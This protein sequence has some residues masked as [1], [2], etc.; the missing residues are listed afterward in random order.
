MRSAPSWYSVLPLSAF[1][2]AS[3]GEKETPATP[4]EATPEEAV[5]APALP[6]VPA[7]PEIAKLSADERAEILGIVGRLAPETDAVMAIYDG[8]GLVEGLRSLKGWKFI[9]EMSEEELGV[10]PEE[11]VG[12]GGP[13][14]DAFLGD[15]FFLAFGD[16]T[17]EQLE[18][19]NKFNSRMTYYQVR[20]FTQAFAEGA[21][22]GDLESAM[23]SAD[24]NAW[25][26]EM[27]RDIGRYM[28]WIENAKA[29]GLLA[30]LRIEDDE[31]R[32]M[33]EQQLR[34]FLGYFGEEVETVEFEKGGAKFSGV[35]FPGSMFAEG[36]E[37][38]R[39]DMAEM[40]GEEATGE[41]IEAVGEK[42]LMVTIGT[43]DDYL[44]L[45]VGSDEEGCPL[46]ASVDESLA[47]SDEIGFIDEFKGQPVHGFL[48][49]AEAVTKAAVTTS[50]KD[51]AE[52]AR[53]GM[54]GVEGIGDTRELV[55][56]LD[57]VGEREA[58]LLDLF[59]PS[60][61]GGVI[62]IDDGL[63]FE[64][65][66][67]S[68]G[69][70]DYQT[71]HQMGALGEGENV[72]LF[73]NWVADETYMERSGEMAE[74]LI[75]TGYATAQHLATMDIE[76]EE[77]EEFQSYFGLFDSMLREDVVTLWEG[78][79]AMSD[80]LGKESAVVVDLN[81]PFPPIPGVPVQVVE[82]GRFVRASYVSPVVDR[83]KLKESWAS[84]YGS[85]RTMLKKLQEAELAELN[86]LS[87]T[88]SEKD[89]LVTW[90]FDALAFS[91]DVKPSVS[92]NDDWFVA[93]TSRN[94]AIDLIGSAGKPAATVRQGSWMRLDLDVMRSYVEEA[95]KL[96]DKEGEAIIVDEDELAEFREALPKI[97]QGIE[98][99]SEVEAVTVHD[100]VERG[101]RR[102]TLHFDAR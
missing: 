17:A 18:I 14:L 11:E 68:S 24:E 69:A 51:L 34:S 52:G 74:L 59:E 28:P 66:G 84:I 26:Q 57:L 67:A 8:R 75:E 31:A 37:G 33:G 45:Y 5:E 10:D 55:A 73:A 21:A 80:G 39:E 102:L 47:G 15:E 72:L 71:P 56:L 83:S 91:D 2:F 3:C 60:S 95:L 58:A 97:M 16:G 101:S 23:E 61:F 40:M 20:M 13:Q 35:S 78:M 12:D 41:L 50:M 89:D 48:Y 38:E 88:S 62:R 77:L 4:P 29:P 46:V 96:V 76:S 98:A 64:T 7:L 30:G 93:S 70:L 25:V 63:V 1:L 65:F 85:I 54:K 36:L 99:M 9:R 6:V 79:T 53:D 27:A 82:E 100:R 92:I 86:M 22:E 87:P 42:S 19:Y 49:G 81:A 44:F 32:G 94:Q 43:L 90:Y